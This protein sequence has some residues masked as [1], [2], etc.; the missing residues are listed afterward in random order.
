MWMSVVLGWD[1]AA[2]T[3]QLFHV[4]IPMAVTAANV[5]LATSLLTESAKVTHDFCRTQ[6][7]YT[8]T[9]GQFEASPLAPQIRLC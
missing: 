3:R 2:L 6:I 4:Q 8:L 7:V 5:S 1:H 9:I